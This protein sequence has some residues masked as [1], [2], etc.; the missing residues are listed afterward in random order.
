MRLA[1]FKHISSKSADYAAAEEYL[2]FEHD[3]FTNKAVRDENGRLIPRKCYRIETVNCGGEDYAIAC[4][5]ANL[6]YG[7]NQRKEDVKSHHY[8]ISFDPRDAEDNGLTLDKAQELGLRFAKEHFPGHQM[9][10]AAHDDGH[11]HSGN[12]HVHIVFNS[13]RI[14]D[15][16]R[17]SY[18]DRPSD[19]KAGMKHRCT[20]AAM[21]YFRSE[22]MEMCHRENLYQIDL[23]HGSRERI[24]EKE[25]RAKTRGQHRIDQENTVRKKA[26][27]P[28]IHTKY[29]T[30]KEKLR[31][32]IREALEKSESMEA[33]S[34]LLLQQGITVR[35]SRGRFSYLMPERTKPI[36]SRRLGDAYSKEAVLSA[37]KDKKKQKLQKAESGRKEGLVGYG[38]EPALSRLVDIEKKRAEG[39]GKGYEYW[40]KIFNL[41]QSAN[42]L[43]YLQENGI[44]SIEEL[45]SFRNGRYEQ[46]NAV[47]IKLKEKETALQKQKNLR[48]QLVVYR[49]TLP[50]I[51]EYR[52]LPEKKRRA[53]CEAC[54]GDFLLYERAVKEL[55][56]VLPDGKIPSLKLVQEEI[57]RL[58]SEKNGR[59]NDYREAKKNYQE[60]V[61]AESNIRKTLRMPEAERHPGREPR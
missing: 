58:I 23:L 10:V 18:M 49:R 42:T 55:K 47:L 4:L 8:I 21:E 36:T 43:I 48:E 5:R 15:V 53:Y 57:E 27:A 60:A 37:I 34:S 45:K 11:H 59:Y 44:H 61:T 35:E 29:E 24:T 17:L 41:K 14:S 6:R 52:K 50:I 51:R 30:D 33:F 9:I 31:K 39:K 3:E 40:A 13:L 28:I 38:K 22:V 7:K 19:T 2:S 20:D 12:I 25:Y 46:M 16:E 54:K 56:A 1:T 26:G 32:A